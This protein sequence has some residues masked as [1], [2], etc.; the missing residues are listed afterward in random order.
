MSVANTAPSDPA[1]LA[2]LSDDAA[3]FYRKFGFEPSHLA[4]DTLMVSLQAIRATFGS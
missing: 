2:A 4:P 1:L 3:A